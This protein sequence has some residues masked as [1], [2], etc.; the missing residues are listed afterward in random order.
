MNK[1]PQ[2]Q[3]DLGEEAVSCPKCGQPTLIGKRNDAAKMFRRF[4]IF[5][6][7]VVGLNGLLGIYGGPFFPFIWGI[8]FVAILFADGLATLTTKQ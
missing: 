3:N 5:W 4:G 6:V 2:C 7:I 8:G 1:C